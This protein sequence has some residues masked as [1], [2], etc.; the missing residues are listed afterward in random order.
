MSA[1]YVME[2]R[3]RPALSDEIGVR[4]KRFLSRQSGIGEPWK[5]PDDERTAPPDITG[6]LSSIVDLNGVLEKGLNGEI[7]YQFRNENQ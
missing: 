2:F 3:H 7:V 5:L 6:E 1:K 4:H